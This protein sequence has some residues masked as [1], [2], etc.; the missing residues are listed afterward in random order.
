MI[1]TEEPLD[2][3]LS[4]FLEACSF[5]WPN[6]KK[7]L[8]FKLEMNKLGLAEYSP[9]WVE[10]LM[11]YVGYILQVWQASIHNADEGESLRLYL[12]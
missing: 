10:D 1:S 3:R 4:H 6:M 8:P 9:L 7:L 5:E 12:R 11:M 2:R